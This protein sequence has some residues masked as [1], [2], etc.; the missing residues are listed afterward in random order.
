MSAKA[1]FQPDVLSIGTS[2]IVPIKTITPADRKS[3][4][5]RRI[6]ASIEHVGLIEPLVVFPTQKDTFLLLD[7]HTRFDIL[8]ATGVESVKCLQSIDNESYT[9]NKRVNYIPPIA[10]HHMILRALAHVSEERIAKA[11]NVSVSR[12]RERR[13]L[14][15]G[16]CPEVAELLRNE[17]VS[18]GALAALRKMKAVRQID[19]A[20]LML[21]A[22]KFTGRF[23]RALLDGTREELLVTGRKRL[24]DV[25]PTDQ[26]MIEQETD[27]M[28]KRADSIRANYGN[29]VLD[30]TTA[31]RYVERL[32][33]NARVQRYLAKYHQDTLSTLRAL[34]MEIKGEPQ[35]SP[36][37]PPANLSSDG[38]HPETTSPAQ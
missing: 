20:R 27:E 10:Q 7:G 6:A 11:L 14:L 25:K 5:Y 3:E 12:I 32:L 36:T 9:Y 28:L 22:R 38:L 37:T 19:V 4:V 31:S 15:R 21:N 24:P 26:S 17:R 35:S 1:G 29:D 34:L 13:D 16:I 33:T 8:C 18:D 2:V 23:T 30:L